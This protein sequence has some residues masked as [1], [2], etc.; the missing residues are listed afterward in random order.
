MV[1]LNS[2]KRYWI[3]YILIMLISLSGCKTNNGTCSGCSTAPFAPNINLKVVDAATKQD[4]FF[5]PNA[6]Y[7]LSL[8]RL[9]HVRLGLL[10]SVPA[11]YG[12]DSTKR[13]LNVKLLYQ[14]PADTIAIQVGTLKPKFLVLY[15]ESLNSC[16][17]RVVV[18][19]AK[20][21]DSL[22]FMAPLDPVKLAKMPNQITFSF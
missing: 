13:L 15:T 3:G 17:T 7:N 19:Q 16:C 14:K 4:L 9:K 1:P 22:I 6:K 8:L 11:V 2:I 12:V 10:D 21:S 5:G 18:T 20:F